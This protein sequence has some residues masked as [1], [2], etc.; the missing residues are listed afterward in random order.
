M[1]SPY[2]H[3]DLF[4]A[5]DIEKYWKGELSAREMHD[6][7]Q[8]AL[9][10][11]FLADAM[12][13]MAGHRPPRPVHGKNES[14]P[15]PDKS[16][17][18]D[19]RVYVQDLDELRQRLNGRITT[20]N[21]QATLILTPWTKIAAAVLLLIG[22]GFTAYYTFLPDR[23][24]ALARKETRASDT[25]GH[26]AIP[27]APRGTSDSS[28]PTG[29]SA[30]TRTSAPA[31][32]ATLA[33]SP[34]STVSS[35][36]A[37]SRPPTASSAPAAPLAKATHRAA[38]SYNH[39]D[40][41]ADSTSIT[42]T[43]AYLRDSIDDKLATGRKAEN[44]ATAL[45]QGTKD[46]ELRAPDPVFLTGKVLD[47][48]DNPLPGA[49]LSF[50]GTGGTGVVTNQQGFFTIKLRPEDSARHLTV[51]LNGYEQASLALN[52]LNADN[53]TMNIIRLQHHPTLDEVVVS[54]Y[55]ASRKEALAT[56]PSDSD[57]KLDSLWLKA[58]PVI[59][60][61]AYLQYLTTAKKTLALDS[62]ITGT[63]T[64]SFEVDKNGV[65]NSFKIEQSLSP[66]H[67]AG[68]IRLVKEGPVWKLLNRRKVRA[69]VK[70]TF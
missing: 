37:I 63:E 27:S 21:R 54:G 23:S 59:G 8:A 30:S 20:K 6:L 10:D 46:K 17:A 50:R 64:L 36:P 12:E 13:G 52:T 33:S 45:D 66:A 35:A 42:V 43:S 15:G 70:M 38:A 41:S 3:N 7:E 55:G 34:T 62:T 26:S 22:L 11:P 24:R 14:D 48:H 68:I 57:V 25:A 44:T 39:T 51:A 40:F 19:R 28:A 49:S 9:D 2:K 31:G 29:S 56:A 47:E 16:P 4:S 60:R 61:E 58:S 67:D 32:S 5:S 1:S 69:V 18:D 53:S 65:L